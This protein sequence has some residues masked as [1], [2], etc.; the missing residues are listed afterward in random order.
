MQKRVLGKSNV[1]LSVLGLGTW[2]IG[3]GD[4]PYGWGKQDDN[5][6]IQ[7]IHHALDLGINWLDTAAGYGKGHS[8]EI[9][10]K[11]LSNRRQEVF[12]ATKCGILWKEDG[13]DIFPCLKVESI[14]NEVELS[15][16]RLKTDYIDLYQIHWPTG[17]D[18]EVAEGWSAVADLIKEG[19]VRFGGVSNFNVSQLEIAN[20]IHPVASL[21]PPYSMLLRGIEGELMEYCH[22]HGIG[23]IAYSPMQAGL[24]SGKMTLER[25]KEFAD[26]DWRK[27][28]SPHFQEPALSI[29]LSF[30]EKIKP[31]AAKHGRPVSHL[32]LAW[33]LRRSEVTGAIVGFRHPYQVDEIIGAG[34]FDLP[35]EDIAVI[36][37]LLKE[38]ENSIIKVGG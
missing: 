14:R 9:V 28:K 22:K 10:G 38:R 27:N 4:N 3:G 30:I 23:I 26:D 34:D 33:V 5:E 20:S 21:Q 37:K 18:S 35:N 32:A 17:E 19:K 8:E 13:S 2:A 24:L 6:S 36:E 12:I 1:E 16:K 11:A 15:L 29:N 7:T 31:I 25:V